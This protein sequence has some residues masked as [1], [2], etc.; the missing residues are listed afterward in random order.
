MHTSQ[1]NCFTHLVLATFHSCSVL[2]GHFVSLLFKLK[3]FAVQILM[4]SQRCIVE[5]ED[6]V[7]CLL[8]SGLGC[9]KT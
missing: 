6:D 1:M 8:K 7:F 5:Y 3:D 2:E 4:Y 9:C